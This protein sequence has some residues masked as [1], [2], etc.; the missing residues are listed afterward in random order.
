MKK[1]DV[2]LTMATLPRHGCA[3]CIWRRAMRKNPW[4]RCAITSEQKWYQAPPCPEYELNSNVPDEVL[5]YL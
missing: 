1:K 5:L 2:T 4:G 3:R